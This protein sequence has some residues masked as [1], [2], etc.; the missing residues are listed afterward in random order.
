MNPLEEVYYGNAL[1]LW[2]LALGT[3]LGIFLSLHVLKRLVVQRLAANAARTP[4]SI[5]DILVGMIRKTRPVFVAAL[6]LYVASFLLTLPAAAMRVV[7]L[8]MII[9][10]LVQIAVWGNTVIDLWVARTTVRRLQQDAGSVTTVAALG[11]FARFVL[12]S[13]ILLLALDNMGVNITALIAGLGITGVAV[14]LAVQNILG[15]LFASLSIML[16]KPFVV[17]DFVVVDGFMGDIEYIGLKTTRLRSLFGEQIIFSNADLL[18]SRIRNYKRMLER[19][20]T[21]NLLL[22][23]EN[24]HDRL[25]AVPA[26]VKDIVNGQQHARFERAHFKEF[27][28]F[29]LMFEVVYF[30]DSADF[31]LYM[32]IQQAINLAIFECFHARGIEFAHQTT[33]HTQRLPQTAAVQG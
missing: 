31:N 14:A 3:L 29:A 11:Y 6:A 12:W 8:I 17:G 30:V 2:L 25:R 23:Y 7:H 10:L 19:R 13:L 22:T 1:G 33:A 28:D 21:F 16:D 20:A 32:D 5:D 27:R 18:K 26:L 15:D 24:T 4:T 9:A